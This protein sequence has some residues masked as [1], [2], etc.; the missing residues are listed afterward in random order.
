MAEHANRTGASVLAASPV[1][2]PRTRAGDAAEKQ[3][4]PLPWPLTWLND[5]ISEATRVWSPFSQLEL[6][7]HTGQAAKP[8]LE[9]RSQAG[10]GPESIDPPASI[11]RLLHASMGRFTHGLS[12]YALWL[13]YADWPVHLWGSPG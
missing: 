5:T 11:D 9:K 8:A 2:V 1:G 13:A 4:Q 3:P 6:D 12:P 7:H 10:E